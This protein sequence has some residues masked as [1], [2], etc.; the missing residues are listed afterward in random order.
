MLQIAGLRS[1]YS[2]RDEK[3]KEDFSPSEGIHLQAS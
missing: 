2:K 1:V 3:I